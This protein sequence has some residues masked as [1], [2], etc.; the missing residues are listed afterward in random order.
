[1]PILDLLPPSLAAEVHTDAR[2]L[3]DLVPCDIQPVW[4]AQNEDPTPYHCPT[5]EEDR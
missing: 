5:P 4:H 1:M 2:P 3:G